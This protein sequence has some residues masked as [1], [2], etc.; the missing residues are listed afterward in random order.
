[1]F[2]QD[3]KPGFFIQALEKLFQLSVIDLDIHPTG[4]ADEVV[5]GI[6]RNDFVESAARHLV[7]MDETMPAEDLQG[8]V[9][10]RLAD[11]R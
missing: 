2:P 9:H 11:V 7:A 5:V 3:Q 1:V 4:M 8:A 10:G 6:G